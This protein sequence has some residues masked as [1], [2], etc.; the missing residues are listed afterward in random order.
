MANEFLFGYGSLI[1][2]NA[3]PEIVTPQNGALPAFVSG[4]RRFWNSYS[5][6]GYAVV[7][8][9]P[10][11]LS[12]CNG[13]LLPVAQ[14]D[15]LKLDAREAQYDRVQINTKDCALQNGMSLP[16]DSRIWAYAVRV[17]VTPDEHSPI[18]QSYLDVILQGCL[19]YGE[20]F[21]EEFIKTT[22][23]WDAPRKADREHPL[24]VRALNT[25][26][27]YEKIEKLLSQSSGT[28]PRL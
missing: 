3:R 8:I 5:L 18:L 20:D 19:E 14:E 11:T 21:A 28:A 9:E 12:R 16:A 1:N 17:T 26:K 23:G 7:A 27:D 24:Y 15:F 2:S 4:Y 22:H 25:S 10:E 6:S 13:V